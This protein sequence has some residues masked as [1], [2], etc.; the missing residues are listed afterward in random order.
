MEGVTFCDIEQL[1][2]VLAEAAEKFVWLRIQEQ[3]GSVEGTF[4]TT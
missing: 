2:E 3:V 4:G 1:H